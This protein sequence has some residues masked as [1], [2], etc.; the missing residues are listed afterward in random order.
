LSLRRWAWLGDNDRF[1]TEE[2]TWLPYRH[3]PHEQ[4]NLQQLVAHW[5]P[6]SDFERILRGEGLR[7]L[8]E[9]DQAQAE[10]ALI[11]RGSECSAHAA[12]IVALCVSGRDDLVTLTLPPSQPRYD[13]FRRKRKKSR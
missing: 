5:V 13:V 7:Q 12:A 1:R 6:S 10:L 3:R 4:Q 2:A 8:E 9:Y 11:P